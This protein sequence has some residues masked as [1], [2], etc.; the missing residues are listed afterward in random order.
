[1]NPKSRR[2]RIFITL[3]ATALLFP[4]AQAASVS[5]A[6][7]GLQLYS[8]RNQFA[9]D[10]PGT[11]A[12][13][14]GWGIKNV[15][16]AGTYNLTSEQFKSQLDAYGLNPVSGHYGYEQYRTNLDWII[17][18][19]KI[20][21]L[22]YVGCAWIPHDGPFDEKTC[23]EAIGVFNHA[24]EVLAQHGL[25]FFSH[26]HGYEFQPFQQGTLFDLLMAETNPKY[27][28]F[29]MDIFWV[30]HAGQDPV[31]LLEKYGQRWQLMH[32]KGMKEST[33]TGFFTGSS[34]V[35]NDVPLGQG[36]IPF[37]PL[38][39]AAAKAGVKWY[40]IEDESAISEQ[41]IPVSLQYLDSLKW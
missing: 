34:D 33:P 30:V 31:K 8:L 17:S 21:G 15:E 25:K 40:F 22:K 16:L 19:A 2:L 5:K 20:L 35:S 32:L 26:T 13:I 36:K 7:T 11:L 10:V 29:E 41:Q 12:E 3:A 1:M 27:V 37:P 38:F 6:Q 23:R 9:K 39:R 24:G 28:N 18:D 4:S 14:K